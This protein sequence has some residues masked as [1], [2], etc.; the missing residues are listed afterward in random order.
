M[1]RTS[2]LL[3][4]V[5]TLVCLGCAGSRYE[6]VTMS[7]RIDLAQHETIGVID[8]TTASKGELGPVTTRRFTEMA[9][10]DQGLVRM[11][12]FGP[13]KKALRSV[14]ERRLGAG[15]FKALG[16]KHGVR[17]ILI[18]E[19]T[20]SEVKP[21]LTLHGLSSGSVTGK[22]DAT[23]AVEMIEAETGASLWNSSARATRSVGQISVG[24][25]GVYVFDAEDPEGAY[26]ELVDSLV[27]QVTRDFR[28]SY[29]R[30]RLE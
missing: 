16:A 8:F 25:G 6:T 14:G 15:A 18:G 30:R 20:V 29:E 5:L 21:D 26:G 24:D 10:R 27:T 17:T 9:R 7:P 12:S 3:L 11:L 13:E 4:A 28:V 2:T 19:L 22:V 23:L 1:G